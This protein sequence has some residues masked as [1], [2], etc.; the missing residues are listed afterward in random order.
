M[1]LTTI[2]VAALLAPLNGREAGYRVSGSD[3]VQAAAAS[4]ASPQQPATDP[5]P[6]NGTDQKQSESKP[7]A[8]PS[9]KKVEEPSLEKPPSN[10]PATAVPKRRARRKKSLT[11]EGEPRKIVIHQGGANEPVS[12]IVPGITQE[13]ANHQRESAEHLLAASESSLEKLAAGSLKPKRQL[14]VVQIRQYMDGARSALNESDTQRA[15]TLALKA[16]LL[17]DDLVKH[18]K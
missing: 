16:Y 15:H 9:D 12:Q 4:E 7:E 14:I 13:E 8:T 3:P 6:A 17:S 2:L 1:Y 11:P 5:V 18:E 10:Q